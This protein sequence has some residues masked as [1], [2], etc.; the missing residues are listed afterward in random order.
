[1]PTSP[2]F[3]AAW[4]SLLGLCAA[5][6]VAHAE[7]AAPPLGPAAAEPAAETTETRCKSGEC[8]SGDACADEDAAITGGVDLAS[9]YIQ[10]GMSSDPDNDGTAL[11]PFV[12]ASLPWGFYAGYWGSNTSYALVDRTT[13]TLDTKPAGPRITAFENDMTLGWGT[14][15][16]HLEVFAGLTALIFLDYHANDVLET[17]IGFDWK[18]RVAGL[19][20][21]TFATVE[22]FLGNVQWG[23][24]GDTYAILTH[25]TEVFSGWWAIADVAIHTYGE[26]GTLTNVDGVNFRQLDLALARRIKETGLNLRANW[27]VG[28]YDRMHRRQPSTLVWSAGWQF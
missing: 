23:N 9:R 3:R 5:V 28:G 11:Q 21:H 6:S 24:R 26:G 4:R 10:R 7:G 8:A 2:S 19:C 1:M 17:N 27:L 25:E 16:G 15:L 18:G 12:N 14:S 13:Q 20:A 22:T